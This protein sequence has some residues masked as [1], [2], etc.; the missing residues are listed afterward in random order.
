MTVKTR[1]DK[2][3]QKHVGEFTKMQP[4]RNFYAIRYWKTYV[5]LFNLLRLITS[6]GR[7]KDVE[8]DFFDFIGRVASL[9]TEE[10]AK[11]ALELLNRSGLS[12]LAK[13]DLAY[14]DEDS[15]EE[16]GAKERLHK[17][18][19]QYNAAQD[20]LEITVVDSFFC[21]MHVF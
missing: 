16:A 6:G 4:D 20:L 7:P 18:A 19:A 12:R 2:L 10:I 17:L 8:Q 11:E 15:D 3:A 14:Y 5:H 9:M 1:L 13:S 21:E